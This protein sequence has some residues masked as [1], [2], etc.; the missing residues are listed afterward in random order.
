ME[1]KEFS[2]KTVEDARK[3]AC[4]EFG[5][6]EEQLEVEVLEPESKS[7]LGMKKNN[8]KIKARAMTNDNGAHSVADKARSMLSTILKYII[9]EGNIEV[10]E[11]DDEVYLNVICDDSGI[12]IGKDGNTLNALQ[13]LLGRM[14]H[15]GDRTGK[16]ICVD[17]GGYRERRKRS[18]Q[19]TVDSLTEKA[20]QTGKPIRVDTANI[21]D[22]W[23]V[24]TMLSNHNKV[25][26]KSMGEG[27]NRQLFIIPHELKGKEEEILKSHASLS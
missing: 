21:F 20:L 27:R 3:E 12:L 23:L 4:H 7:F 9:G 22:R 10:R 5:V 26:T 15:R 17:V 25:Y 24:H 6:R 1:W 11:R 18:L 2:A 16:L 14:V 19:H 8:A 13:Y